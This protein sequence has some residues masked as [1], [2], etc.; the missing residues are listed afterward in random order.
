[1][2]EPQELHFQHVSPIVL[3][4]ADGETPNGKPLQYEASLRILQSWAE[5]YKIHLIIGNQ[6]KHLTTESSRVFLYD[7]VKRHYHEMHENADS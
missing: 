5:S 6:R 3:W 1:M 2:S 4:T 7:Y